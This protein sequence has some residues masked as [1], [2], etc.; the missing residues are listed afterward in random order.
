MVDLSDIVEELRRWI[1]ERRLQHSMGVSRCAVDL[2]RHYGVDEAKAEL[3]GL[4]HDCAK[5][6]SL[7]KSLDLGRKYGFEAD[8]ISLNNNALLH[9]PL[10]A[11][12]A[13]DLFGIQDT[14]VLEAIAC[15]TTGKENMSL[16]DKII[17][18]ADYIEVDRNYPGVKEIRKLAY[19]DLNESVIKALELS[20]KNVLERGRLLHPMTIEARNYLIMETR[21]EKDNSFHPI[22]SLKNQG[23]RHN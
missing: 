5:C 13:G 15:H 10:G 14:E 22:K 23:K 16:L 3:A 11:Y 8:E 20:I 7:D 1:D 21:D 17:F 9:A 12:L 4:V 18:V 6:L 19:A 2:A